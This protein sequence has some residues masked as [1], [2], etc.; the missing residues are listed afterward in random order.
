MWPILNRTLAAFVLGP[1]SSFCAC[2]GD[3]A[4]GVKL[5]TFVRPKKSSSTPDRAFEYVQKA[6]DFSLYHGQTKAQSERSRLHLSPGKSPRRSV[7]RDDPKSGP[8]GLDVGRCP[9]SSQ[10]C[11]RLFLPADRS[12]SDAMRSRS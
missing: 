8:A 7:T 4:G 9:G 2:G 12:E 6:A 11:R 10:P 1:S 3:L 5:N